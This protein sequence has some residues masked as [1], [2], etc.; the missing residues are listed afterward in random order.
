[1]NMINFN[2]VLFYVYHLD[3]RLETFESGKF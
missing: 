1:M 2:I 3:I